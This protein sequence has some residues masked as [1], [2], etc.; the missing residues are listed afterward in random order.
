MKNLLGCNHYFASLED[1]LLAYH[2]DRLE[3]HTTIWVRYKDENLEL[4]TPF[5]VSKFKNQS[6]IEYYEN[7]QIRKGE[8]NAIIVQYIRTTPGRVILNHTI[9]KTLK[10]FS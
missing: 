1:V 5:K 9:Q 10:L 8:D 7:A 4:K 2:Q 6:Y 3:L